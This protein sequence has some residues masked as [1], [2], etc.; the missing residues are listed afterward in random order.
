MKKSIVILLSL[1]VLIAF[2]VYYISEHY[3]FNPVTF[4]KDQVTPHSWTDYERPL[5]ITIYSFEEERESE[6]IDEEEDIR[7]FILELKESPSSEADATATDV[8]G[9]L[10]L[11]ANDRT[12]LE[13]LFYPN[14]WEVLKR[15]GPAFE[16]TDSLKQLVDRF[17]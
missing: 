10:T 6:T 7:E 12:L 4:D 9:G 13:V 2:G 16:I 1:G 15:E 17:E 5:E 11:T 14:H 8:R 3:F